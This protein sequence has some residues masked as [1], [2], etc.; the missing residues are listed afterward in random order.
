MSSKIP[1]PKCSTQIG[2]DSDFCFVCG[3]EL[4]ASSGAPPPIPQ[5]APTSG[6]A[7][8]MKKCPFC[9]EDIQAA[10]IVCKHCGRD[11]ATGAHPSARQPSYGI[12]ALLSLIIPGA[13]QMYL[14]KVGKGLVW[15]VLTVFFYVAFLPLGF[16]VHIACIVAAA[17]KP[18]AE[19]R[20]EMKAGAIAEATALNK[21]MSKTAIALTVI[22]IAVVAAY[23]IWARTLQ[24]QREAAATAAKDAVSDRPIVVMFPDTDGIRFVNDSDTDLPYCTVTLQ[25]DYSAV[26]GPI[27]S[28]SR[29]FVER[30]SFGSELMSR[31]E[32]ARRVRG[33][34]ELTCRQSEKG[35][36]VDVALKQ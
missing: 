8:A 9:A 20:R 25:G 11:L 30:E 6:A 35:P 26:L 34:V 4:K 19:Q 17:T 31:A 1:C 23:A 7:A 13:G 12:A 22:V 10:A 16:I 27:H 21:P 2:A 29:A 32:F 14:G 18:I 3:Y 33:A 15:L 36:L 24:Q 5:A 28:K